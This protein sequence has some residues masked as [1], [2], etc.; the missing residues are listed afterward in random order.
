MW[1]LTGENAALSPWQLTWPVLQSPR[2][3][4]CATCHTSHDSPTGGMASSCFG[5]VSRNAQRCTGHGQC[6][7]LAKGAVRKL[8]ISK[9]FYISNNFTVFL[10]FYTVS[11][12]STKLFCMKKHIT[13]IVSLNDDSPLITFR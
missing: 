10:R 5:R 2:Q 9:F 8:I 1:Q 11:K 4:T 7:L 13:I 6:C 12:Y 3:I